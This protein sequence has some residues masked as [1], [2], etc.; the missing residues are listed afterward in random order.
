M[1][2]FVT[3]MK[4]FLSHQALAACVEDDKSAESLTPAQEI[5]FV[6]IVPESEASR[7][8]EMCCGRKRGLV[9]SL[10]ALRCARGG[11]GAAIY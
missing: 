2:F 7:D 9:S 8:Y 5:Y 10:G 11:F 4:I 1:A 6:E 3:K